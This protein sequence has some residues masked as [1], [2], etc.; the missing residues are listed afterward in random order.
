MT[1]FKMEFYFEIRLAKNHFTVTGILMV[2]VQDNCE[3]IGRCQIYMVW[4]LRVNFFK[5]ECEGELH[6][7]MGTQTS[8]HKSPAQS[9]LK[10]SV[11]S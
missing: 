8:L 6:L 10:K 7:H 5:G 1:S 4:G 3:G 11:D 9:N 2:E